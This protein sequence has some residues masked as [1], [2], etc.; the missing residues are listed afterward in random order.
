MTTVLYSLE[1]PY[2]IAV[3]GGSGFKTV[4]KDLDKEHSI[5]NLQKA[6]NC[7]FIKRCNTNIAS[8]IKTATDKFKSLD[9]DNSH[10]VFYMFTN[11]T[12]EELTLYEQWKERIFINSNHSLAFI[13]SKPKTIKDEQSEF[14]T[15]FW[16][17]FGKYC[18]DNRLPVELIEINKEKLYIQNKNNLEIKEQ[19]VMAYIKST[20]NVL[21]R[22]KEKDNNEKFEK[23]F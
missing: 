14:L 6:L 20:I 23:A 17:K 4:L 22:V 9:F 21:R 2:L 11:G 1:I 10:R 12:D 15:Q 7:I 8:C 19:N 5:E 18:K 3:V 13:F 16:N